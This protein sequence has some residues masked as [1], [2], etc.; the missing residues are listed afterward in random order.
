MAKVPKRPKARKEAAAAEKAGKAAARRTDVIAREGKRSGRPV[1]LKKNFQNEMTAADRIRFYLGLPQ[2]Y[3]MNPVLIDKARAKLHARED[4]TPFE[5]QV[6]FD[7]HS[8]GAAQRQDERTSGRSFWTQQVG[9]EAAVREMARS[10]ERERS[11]A[12]DVLLQQASEGDD[13]MWSAQYALRQLYGESPL[14]P[15]A[16]EMGLHRG[17]PEVFPSQEAA[18]PQNPRMGGV[19]RKH[20][21]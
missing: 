8:A 6:M 15:L 16:V 4:R 10:A 14:P 1:K 18:Q 13:P 11:L 7:I 20:G 12:R 3:P 17:R 2:G 5:V 19:K 21:Y 9:P